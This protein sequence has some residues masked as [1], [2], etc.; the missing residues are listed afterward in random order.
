MN[1]QDLPGPYIPD[2]SDTILT[3][4][5]GSDEDTLISGDREDTVISG[6]RD[7]TLISVGREDTIIS[8][9]N[10]DTL[11]SGDRDETVLNLRQ[12][13]PAREASQPREIQHQ[14]EPALP[15]LPKLPPMP[16]SASAQARRSPALSTS[17]HSSQAH[18]S[19]T[20]SAPVSGVI[21]SDGRQLLLT[22]PVVVGRRPQSTRIINGLLPQLIHVNSAREL[23]SSTHAEIRQEGSAVIVTDLGSTNGTVV[24]LPGIPPRRLRAGEST[25][26]TP[27]TRVDLGDSIVLT[28]VA[29][30][31]TPTG[32]SYR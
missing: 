5:S 26:V 16:G 20:H 19:P 6:G 11:I 24:L 25:A 21:L 14:S 9:G 23:I 29:P 15:E 22:S 1:S 10:D 18:S 28:L 8:G 17:A 27:G 12:G 3:R 31:P 7:D 32:G 30:E 4:A 13:Y 2:D